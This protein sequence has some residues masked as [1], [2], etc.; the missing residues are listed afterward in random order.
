LKYKQVGLYFDTLKYL[1]AKQIVYRLFYFAR[2]KIY[3]LLGIKPLF[4]IDTKVQKLHFQPFVETLHSYDSPLCFTFLNLQKCFSGV[5]DWDYSEFGKLWTYNLNYFD[6]LLQKNISK[7]EALHLI[8]DFCTSL[9]SLQNAVEPYPISLR[10]MNWIKFFSTQ[11]ISNPKLDAS[12]YA[13]YKILSRNIEYHLLGNHLLENGFSLLFAAY[14]FED[15][16]FYGLAKKILDDEL[17]EQMLGDGAHFELSPMYH[18]IMLLRVL[19]SINL[20]QNNS[21]KNNELLELLTSKAGAMLGWL[22][23]MSFQNGNTPHFNDSTEEIAQNTK[24]LFEYA[25]RLGVQKVATILKDSGYRKFENDKY[26]II[27]DVGNIGADYIPGHAHS[28]TFNF[29]L[30]VDGKAIIVDTS[31]STY[32][33]GT[34][35]SFERSTAAHNT[36]MVD[37][38]EQSEIWGG[39]RVGKRAKIVYLCE[40]SCEISATHDGYASLGV[41]H[42]RKFVFGNKS[43]S[44][45]DNLGQKCKAKAFLHF[46]HGIEPVM[47]GDKV[48]VDKINIT[49]KGAQKI[50]IE[51]YEL[52]LGFNKTVT[53]KVVTVEF[54][55][56]LLT[57]IFV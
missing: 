28:D 3:K 33:I 8:D 7:D 54:D 34:K 16:E 9:P 47:D 36:V 23:N 35:R 17:K 21:Y 37:W 14:Y 5:A 49:F 43:I 46:A 20:V 27:I 38:R 10:G 41:M 51:K 24:E 15:K 31:T 25:N 22:E 44:I 45:A 11:D 57:D 4:S 56:M 48:S 40:S 52:A 13:Q 55:D 12:L 19:D 30:Y 50:D 29:E 18:K 6:F 2:K 1:R 42:K 39:F 26:E 53:A 32:E